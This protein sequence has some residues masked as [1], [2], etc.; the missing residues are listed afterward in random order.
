MEYIEITCA[1]QL[2]KDMC[3]NESTEIIGNNINYALLNNQAKDFHKA[4]YFKGYSFSNFYP[5][6]KDGVYKK[7]NIYTFT[8]NVIKQN[9]KYFVNI[10]NNYN[11]NEFKV[12]AVQE[13]K[14]NVRMIS[15][16]FTI[17]PTVIRLDSNK[18]WTKGNLDILIDQINRKLIKKYK[19]FFNEE[20]NCNFIEQIKV[21]SKSPIIMKYK[22]FSYAGIKLE[23]I[24]NQD[25]DSQKLAQLAKITGI[26][27]LN[28]SLGCGFSI[29]HNIY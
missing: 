18:V 10:F 12:L 28:S 27:D 5:A 21:L 14:R 22:N 2:K 15:Q 16:L 11:S 23:I 29:A 6:Q 8:I 13:Q 20:L 25:A 19:Q 9:H 3:W 17:N 26:G 4:P 1:V 7:D 24:V